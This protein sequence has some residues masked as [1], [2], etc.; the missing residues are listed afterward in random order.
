MKDPIL[1]NILERHRN[2]IRSGPP[3]KS[4]FSHFTNK[5]SKLKA[6]LWT[7][8]ENVFTHRLITETSLEEKVEN[9]K[10]IKMK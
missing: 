2:N 9:L 8:A 6:Y 4:A 7:G 10:S 3:V 1:N 5:V